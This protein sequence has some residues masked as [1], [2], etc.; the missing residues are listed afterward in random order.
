MTF[1]AVLFLV[2]GVWLT[3]RRIRRVERRVAWELE[4]VADAVVC[5]GYDDCPCGC[6]DWSDETR[7]ELAWLSSR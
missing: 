7:E 4:T 5:R 2:G 3:I 6:L 1:L